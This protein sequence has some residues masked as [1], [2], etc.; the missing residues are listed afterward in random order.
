MACLFPAYSG[1]VLWLKL[2]VCLL[3]LS[4][5]GI[6]EQA[7]VIDDKIQPLLGLYVHFEQLQS[8]S[9]NAIRL[10]FLGFCACSE[11]LNKVHCASW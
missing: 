3:L 10:H 11:I 7:A 1:C 2:T 6:E 8:R 5:L 4:F 9:S